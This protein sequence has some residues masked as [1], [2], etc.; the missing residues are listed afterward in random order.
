MPAYHSYTNENQPKTL[1]LSGY[2]PGFFHYT[3]SHL[4]KKDGLY[5]MNGRNKRLFT[6]PVF[7]LLMFLLAACSL[8]AG[9]P[10]SGDGTQAPTQA[11]YTDPYATAPEGAEADAEA[12]YPN[13]GYA[14]PA[15]A[16]TQA[17]TNPLAPTSINVPETVPSLTPAAAQ[18]PQAGEP[19]LVTRQTAEV[20]RG[21][22]TSYELSHWLDSGIT[23]PVQGRS[24][25]GQWWVIPGAGDGPGPLGWISS[26]EVVFYGD[27]ALV[28]VIQTPSNPADVPVHS[29]PGSPPAGACVVEPLGSDVGPVLVRLGPG[30]QYNVT[31]RLGGW[32]EVINTQMGWH[33]ILLGPGEVGWVD[34]QK[35]QASGPCLSSS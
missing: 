30:E 12:P 16:G 32:A 27:P 7:G 22:G 33:Q 3:E 13:A 11:A 6:L 8:P 26:E 9:I 20:R 24:E 5:D 31:H 1:L 23:A 21:P 2:P 4:Y 17:Y 14:N 35:V 28:P 10:V 34:G 18:P 15:P 29:D 19:Y 25:D